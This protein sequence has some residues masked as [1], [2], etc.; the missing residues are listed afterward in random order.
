MPEGEVAGKQLLGITGWFFATLGCSAHLLGPGNIPN[1]VPEALSPEMEKHVK[2]P[3]A[4]GDLGSSLPLPQARGG[5]NTH[6]KNGCVRW[7]TE[8]AGGIF[9][10]RQRKI[11]IICVRQK[12]HLQRGDCPGELGG[13]RMQHSQAWNAVEGALKDVSSDTAASWA[14]GRSAMLWVKLFSTWNIH[15]RSGFALFV[16]QDAGGGAGV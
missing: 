8:K 4:W 1:P 7:K 3:L 12:G 2:I 13:S 6:G 14:E 11:E 15:G 10:G 9:I 5:G 16:S